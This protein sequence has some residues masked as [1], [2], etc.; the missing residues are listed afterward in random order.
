MT[1][2]TLPRTTVPV[3]KTT[4]CEVS[5]ESEELDAPSQP[6]LGLGNCLIPEEE[7]DQGKGSLLFKASSIRVGI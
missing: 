5:K 4:L 7:G 1:G 6:T 2:S 3:K